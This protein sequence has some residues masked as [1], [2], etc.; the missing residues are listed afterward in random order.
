MQINNAGLVLLHSFFNPLFSRL[1]LLT[2]AGAF[3]SNNAQHRAVHVLQFLVTGQT[4]TLD[5]HLTLNKLLCGLPP[6]QPLESTSDIT[7]AEHETCFELLS[8]II[9]N[10]PAIGAMSIDGFRGN[11]LVRD[12]LLANAND[13]WEMTVKPRP[14]DVLLAHSPFSFS[15][16]RHS[17]MDKPLFVT[18]KP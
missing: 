11:W 12:G 8:M 9:D 6:D 10:R 16:I 5:Q 7:D 13:R 17:W 3:V 1:D 4:E 14:Y 15:V 2:E 18:W